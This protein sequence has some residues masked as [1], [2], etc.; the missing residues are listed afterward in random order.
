[1]DCDEGKQR[2]NIVHGSFKAR[3]LVESSGNERGKRAHQE[4]GECQHAQAG[5]CNLPPHD[6]KHSC[7]QDRLIR[8]EEE[9]EHR[10]CDRERK[11]SIE[12]CQ[13]EGSETRPDK[14]WRQY[15]LAAQPVRKDTGCRL[16]QQPDGDKQR[17]VESPRRGTQLEFIVQ[18]KRQ[19]GHQRHKGHPTETAHQRQA[20]EDGTPEK[21]SGCLDSPGSSIT[22]F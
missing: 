7:R 9:S 22:L 20:P 4:F 6:V 18:V 13:S 16:G 19:D 5:G 14:P 11:A 8:V 10:D 1:M 15:L 12:N 21:T 2:R 17:Y 3:S